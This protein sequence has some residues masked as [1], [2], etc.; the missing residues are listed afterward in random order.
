MA[1]I[2]IFPIKVCVRKEE[3]PE[4]LESIMTIT[5]EPDEES[6][7]KTDTVPNINVNLVVESNKDEH[8]DYICG[9][10]WFDNFYAHTGIHNLLRRVNFAC[11]I[12]VSDDVEFSEAAKEKL[13]ASFGV[14][15]SKLKGIIED[16]NTYITLWPD[17][18]LFTV[19]MGTEEE[20]TEAIEEG[21]PTEEV[22]DEPK[23]E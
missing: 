10:N 23:S 2:E 1:K 19:T 12:R 17:T 7:K 11:N 21:T 4:E 22:K 3:K 18:P 9:L 16:M 13:N 8:I 15:V 14:F 20:K 6:F 5:F